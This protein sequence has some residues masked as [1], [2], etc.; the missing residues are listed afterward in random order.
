MSLR[1]I[2]VPTFFIIFAPNVNILTPKHKTYETIRKK[3]E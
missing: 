2:I 1:I 3:R